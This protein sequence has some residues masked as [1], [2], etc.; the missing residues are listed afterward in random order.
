MQSRRQ[1][2]GEDRYLERQAVR[3]HAR[4][5]GQL[6][7]RAD[8]LGRGAREGCGGILACL[9]HARK[10]GRVAHRESE[11]VP[12][13]ECWSQYPYN[14]PEDLRTLSDQ[15]RRWAELDSLQRLRRV[16]SIWQT[17]WAVYAS[18]LK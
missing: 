9:L 5:K 10:E 12:F 16:S 14:A 7:A 4:H 13:L 1:C 3:D 15:L 18:A 8:H 2:A 17:L 11:G 6:T